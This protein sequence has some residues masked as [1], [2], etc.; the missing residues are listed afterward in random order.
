MKAV[1]PD[2]LH[3]GQPFGGNALG[4]A[5]QTARAQPHAG[6]IEQPL[7]FPVYLGESVSQ[8]SVAGQP[9]PRQHLSQAGGIA[10]GGGEFRHRAR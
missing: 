10:T 5:F 4:G 7:H 8:R 1:Q 2:S 3:A 9:R 6:A